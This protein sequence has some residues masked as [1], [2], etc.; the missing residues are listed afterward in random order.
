MSLLEEYIIQ[1]TCFY[2]HI[3]ICK[4]IKKNDVIHQKDYRLTQIVL[5]VILGEYV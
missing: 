2:V 1:L 5:L 4:C 3:V